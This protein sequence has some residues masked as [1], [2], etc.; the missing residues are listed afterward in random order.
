M[1][2]Y[3]RVQHYPNTNNIGRWRGGMLYCSCSF[4]DWY[5]ITQCLKNNQ[6]FLDVTVERRAPEQNSSL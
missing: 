1:L 3:A 6:P 5:K 4:H 2:Q